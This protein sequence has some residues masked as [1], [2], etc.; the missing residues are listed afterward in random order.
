[1][2]VHETI[3]IRL[4]FISW[5]PPIRS[6]PIPLLTEEE[7]KRNPYE[8][9]NLEFNRNLVCAD[10]GSAVQCAWRKRRK[11]FPSFL[12]SL[13]F[14][15]GRRCRHGLSLF[16]KK[17]TRRE[18]NWTY[19]LWILYCV[20]WCCHRAEMLE[21]NEDRDRERGNGHTSIIHA[22]AIR[23]C[24]QSIEEVRR[25]RRRRTTSD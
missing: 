15:G 9:G 10:D 17:K 14:F 8:Y 3:F 1:M 4:L 21:K 12:E 11:T 18:L 6:D 23:W 25:R 5:P 22:D 24:W 20:L 16:Y 7:E 13:S 2:R 19:L